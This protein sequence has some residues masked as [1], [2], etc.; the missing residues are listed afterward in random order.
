MKNIEHSNT[1][2][3]NFKIEI[4]LFLEEQKNKSYS[5]K[6]TKATYCILQKKKKFNREIEDKIYVLIICK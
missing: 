5:S 2:A 3:V 1:V 4:I 6:M